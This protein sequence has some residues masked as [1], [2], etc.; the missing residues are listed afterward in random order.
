MLPNFVF[1][2]IKEPEN[3]D[4]TYTVRLVNLAVVPIRAVILR[5]APH[6][7]IRLYYFFIFVGKCSGFTDLCRDF[8]NIAKFCH[9]VK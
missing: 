7:S 4:I 1:R 3:A 9:S 5:I 8:V 6:F 2:L